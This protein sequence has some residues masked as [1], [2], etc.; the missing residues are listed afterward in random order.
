ME[1]I[2][3]L[4]TNVLLNDPYSV[5]A[6]NEHKVIIPMTVLEE[7]DNIKGKHTDVS[8]DARV[9]IRQIS[10]IIGDATHE[11]I[12]KGVKLNAIHDMFPD[13][14]TLAIVPDDAATNYALSYS[15]LVLLADVT[16]PDNRIINTA[17]YVQEAFFDSTVILVTN[18]I[19]MKIKAKG[20]GVN[21]VESYGKEKTLNDMDLLHV[22]HVHVENFWK[23]YE[24][25]EVNSEVNKQRRTVHKVPLIEDFKELIIND[26]V[27]DDADALLRLVGKSETHHYFYDIGKG[28]AL[29]KKVWGIRSINVEQ[30]MAIDALTDKDIDIVILLGPAG[31]GKAQ[32]LYSKILTPTGWTT[33]GEIKVGDTVSTPDGK[34]ASVTGLFPQGKKDIYRVH[35]KDGRYADCCEDHLWNIYCG[36]FPE[37][38]RE[39]TVD[40][41]EIIRLLSVNSK[42]DRLFIQQTKPIEFVEKELP[43]HPYVLG[44]LLGDGHLRNSGLYFSSA[45]DFI[46]S[47]ID[48]LLGDNYELKRKNDY[49]YR[50]NMTREKFSE[51]HN[52]RNT[53]TGYRHPLLEELDTL[54][55][56]GTKSDTKFIPEEY[57]WG[58]VE[59]RYQLLRGLM[60]TDGE[61]NGNPMISTASKKMAEQIQYLVRSLGGDA[62]YS[63]S[64]PWYTYKGEK[65]QG[66]PAHQISIKIQNP[67][68]MFEL[69]RKQKERV[70]AQT[71]RNKII[72]VEKIGYEEAQC[73]MI[74]HQEHLYITDDFIVTHNT[75]LTVAAGLEQTLEKRIFDRTVITRSQDSQFAD[76]G[77]LPGTLEEKIGPSLG[78]V[79]DSLEFLH[80]D[81][82]D[83]FESIKHIRERGILKYEALN[84]IR[85]R[86]YKDT[87][88]VIDEAQNLTPQMMKT[89]CTRLG[90]GSKLVI[91]GNLAQIDN[92]YITEF[93][94]GLTYL[95]E[96]FK[97]WEGC[98]IVQLQNTVRSRLA[99]FAEQNL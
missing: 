46:I 21:I 47:R 27:Y 89:I 31:T 85:G 62:V 58:S 68:K 63:V 90:T 84:F 65:K 33:M 6:F 43:V 44:A 28:K 11:E 86:S 52:G 72:S 4:D 49:D 64:N 56:L 67:E 78:C 40:T 81:D 69:P 22:G 36:E 51:T 19:N 29:N 98:A 74:D 37:T 83:P 39:R 14:A 38:S 26:Y 3:V 95:V 75:L 73:I 15:D 41:K 50:I 7:L 12:V 34:S 70:R 60:D 61:T 9:A 10:E 77:F 66:L 94:S 57:L 55:L 23:L 35:F 93:S 13:T 48:A 88:L 80:K 92:P 76:I 82:R 99:E 20:A 54:K 42:K 53:N 30:S 17:H 96:K 2:F 87:L 32:P 16:V 8:R 59:Q 97:G 25:K 24:D 79:Q 71:I 45:D 5:L 91:M 1:K 18:D